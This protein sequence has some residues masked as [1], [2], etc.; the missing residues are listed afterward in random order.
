MHILKFFRVLKCFKKVSFKTTDS[1]RKKIEERGGAYLEKEYEVIRLIK[2]NSSCHI[3]TDCARGRTLPEYI[4][5]CGQM[6]KLQLFSYLQ[7]MIKQLGYLQGVRGVRTYCYSTPFCMIIKANDELALLDLNAK[8]NQYLVNQIGREDI[9]SC[10]FK[11][12]NLYDVMFPVGKTIQYILAKVNVVPKLTKR[13]EYKLKKIISKCL[14]DR[15]KKQ[16]QKISDILYDIPKLEK[17]LEK[18]KKSERKRVK[19]IYPVVF[20]SG[21]SLVAGGMNVV[22]R[23]GKKEEEQVEIVQEESVDFFEIG[24][25]YFLEMEDYRKSKEMFERSKEK[26]W[27]SRQYSELADYMMGECTMSNDEV[28]EVLLELGREIEEGRKIEEKRI[29][30]RVWSKMETE[31]AVQQRIRL[32]EE[33]L[34]ENDIDR[35]AENEIR[36]VMAEAYEKNGQNELALEQ[37]KVINEWNKSE[38][39]YRS[40]IRTAKTIDKSKAVQFC[41][42]GIEEN[43][44]SKELRAQLIQIQCE[45][46]SVSKEVCETN[47]KKMIAECPQLLQEESFQKLQKEYGIKVEGESIWVEK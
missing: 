45:D 31:A 34:E 2:Q 19:W 33:L 28:E 39:I 42:E 4:E 9:R 22:L 30:F 38:E 13:E 40:M 18:R 21:V 5:E 44:T 16:Y 32:G 3:I 24:M 6:E 8:G 47:I 46:K 25:T 41:E 27:I 29:L 23:M 10:F 26:Q 36:T 1:I 14:S 35:E 17:K 7:Q 15:S 12:G 11:K 20:L 37:Y 43:P